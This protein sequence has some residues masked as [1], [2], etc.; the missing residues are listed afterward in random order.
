[1]QG[2]KHGTHTRTHTLNRPSALQV[3]CV[4]LCEWCDCVVCV[5]RLTKDELLLELLL[6]LVLGSYLGYACVASQ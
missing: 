3:M 4:C 2:R 5:H 6:Q 1:M